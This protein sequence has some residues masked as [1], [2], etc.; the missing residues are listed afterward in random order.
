ME[1][2][3]PIENNTVD[4][5]YIEEIYHTNQ[6]HHEVVM[7]NTDEVRKLVLKSAS[8]SCELILCLHNRLPTADYRNSIAYHN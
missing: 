5:N 7:L 1:K 3:T 4:N 8:K 2:L 6:R